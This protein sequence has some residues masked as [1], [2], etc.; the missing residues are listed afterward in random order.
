[1]PRVT[2]SIVNRNSKIGNRVKGGDIDV[3]RADS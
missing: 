1:V 2:L 3:A